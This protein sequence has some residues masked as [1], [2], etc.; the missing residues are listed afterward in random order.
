MIRF[1]A[2]LS[3]TG[4]ALLLS[5]M[6]GCAS[7]TAATEW[8]LVGAYDAS[9]ALAAKAQPVAGYVWA[10]APGMS[11]SCGPSK[12]PLGM[13][14]FETEAMGNGLTPT[15]ALVLRYGGPGRPEPLTPT[16][17]QVALVDPDGLEDPERRFALEPALLPRRLA[18]EV[19]GDAESEQVRQLVRTQLSIEL[20]LEHKVGRAWLGS[21]S[22]RVRQAFMLDRPSGE[23]GV[24]EDRR[25]FVGQRDPVPALLG[26]PDACAISLDGKARRS[27]EDGTSGAGASRMVASDIWGAG[28]RTC[29]SRD[30]KH[31]ED[32]L[33]KPDL[34]ELRSSTP[35]GS[36]R[37]EP[38][39]ARRITI[40]VTRDAQGRDLFDLMEVKMEGGEERTTPLMDAPAPLFPNADR[41]EGSTDLTDVLALLPHRYPM[42]RDGAS[43]LDNPDAPGSGW[44][45][46]LLIPDWQ[47]VQGITKLG[48]GGLPAAAPA[49]LGPHLDPGPPGIPQRAGGPRR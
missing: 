18:L 11:G 43:P 4:S 5:G 42:V 38:P 33:K 46:I 12:G 17:L 15:L 16:T 44:Y 47:L 31:P 29:T 7:D 2:T 1:P 30:P 3:L 34:L 25:F 45:T 40:D 24:G 8:Q 21:D 28:L 14:I 35:W 9:A 27:S 22:E 10:S 32:A 41:P 26:P 20:C 13:G 39:P 36:L 19:R 23:G 49:P 37:F 6:L 48:T